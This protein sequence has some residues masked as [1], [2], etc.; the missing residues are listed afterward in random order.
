MTSKRQTWAHK[1]HAIML[2]CLADAVAEAE[3]EYVCRLSCLQHLL[4]VGGVDLLAQRSQ[5]SPTTTTASAMD[6]VHDVRS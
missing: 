3:A 6:P 2:F 1:E 5:L 4:S